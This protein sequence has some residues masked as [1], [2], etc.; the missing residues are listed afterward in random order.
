MHLH[1]THHRPVGPDAADQ[2]A[3]T[4]PLATLAEKINAEHRV[5]ETALRQSLAHAHLAGELLIQA[6][7]QCTHGQWGGWLTD[8]FEGSTRTAQAYMRVAKRWPELESKAQRVALLA[9][10]EALKILADARP[11][12][13]DHVDGQIDAVDHADECVDDDVN[14]SSNDD[15]VADAHLRVVRVDYLPSDDPP[16]GQVVRVSYPPNDNAPNNALIIRGDARDAPPEDQVDRTNG[17]ELKQVQDA[18]EQRVETLLEAAG[19]PVRKQFFA[20]LRTRIG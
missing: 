7:Q 11:S 2:A 5:V 13:E 10:R 19:E 18:Y 15:Q 20:W 9:Y 6:K 4:V 1:D 8:N 14:A 12:D 17:I 16:E 3:T